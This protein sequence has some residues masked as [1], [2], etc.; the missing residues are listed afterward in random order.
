MCGIVG[1]IGSEQAKSLLLEGI[2]RLEYRGY[3]SAGLALLNM[4]SQDFITKRR[5]GAVQNLIEACKEIG[6]EETRG[7]AH[8]RWATHG[9]PSETNAHPHK[10][11]DIALVH[12]GIIENYAELREFLRAEGH[13]FQ[14]QTDTEVIAAQLDYEIT[15]LLAG[16]EF[17]GKEES[18]KLG[19]VEKALKATVKKLHGHYAIVFMVKALPEHIFGAQMGAPLV[20]ASTDKGCF[21]A[22]DMQAILPHTREL[23]FVPQEV[24][25]HGTIAGKVYGKFLNTDKVWIPE[26]EQIEWSAEEV[27]KQG[28]PTYMLKEILE[29]PTVVA[30]CLSGRLPSGDA[31]HFVWENPEGHERLWKKAKKVHLIACGTAFYAANIAKYFFEKWAGLPVEIDLASEFRYRS[32]LLEEGSVVGVVSQS[33]ETADTLAALRL[34]NEAGAKTFCVCNVPAS[35][36]VRESMFQYM[37]KAGP[38]IGVASTK[39]FTAQLS[40]LA[41]LAL[42]LAG[43]RQ[44]ARS[45]V[46]EEIKAIARLPHDLSQILDQQAELR[47]L[48]SELKEYRTILFV[49]RGVMYPVAL[50]GALKL[51]E[52]T[53]RHA[54]GYAAG[55]LK[56]GPIALVDDKLVAVVLS[57]PDHV[58]SKTLS[59]LEEIKA[60][61]GHIIG[62]GEEGCAQFEKL[63]NRYIGLPKV[64]WGC[65]PLLYTVPCQLIAYGLAEALGC[66]IDKPRNLAKSVTVE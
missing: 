63:C 59:N 27:E 47:D 21:L 30:N 19:I 16:T 22:S 28:H 50:E 12:N 17:E 37:T 66:D 11:G 2:L 57:P 53:Y 44:G 56:H 62:V 25:L 43:Q 18:E 46:K 35:T 65:S 15:T 48:G 36:I 23:S 42:D 49:G 52:I 31:E 13:E 4:Q 39:A 41:S 10:A 32:P 45:N 3:D 55:E 7:I 58:L 9:V 40:V 64:S 1:Y 38:E 60:R 61:G 26:V 5:V 20:V 34:A 29:Q 51:K 8:T 33:G 54:E 6:E 14:S 24:V